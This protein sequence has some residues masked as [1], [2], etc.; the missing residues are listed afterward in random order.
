MPMAAETTV[1]CEKGYYNS[2]K[3]SIYSAFG[4]AYGSFIISLDYVFTRKLEKHICTYRTVIKGQ[5]LSAALE[6][7]HTEYGLSLIHI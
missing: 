4:D 5:R 7:L 6:K 2:T 1:L 3:S